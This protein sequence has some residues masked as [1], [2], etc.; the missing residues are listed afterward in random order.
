MDT[1]YR[2]CEAVTRL[3]AANFYYG[4]RLLPAPKQR[5]MCAIY[6]FARRVDDIG[7]GELPRDEKIRR[8]EAERERL[9]WNGVVDDPVIA[10]LR[11]VHERFSLPLDALESLIDGV[12][13]DARGISYGSFAELVVYCRQVAGS[14]GRLSLAIFGTSEWAEASALADDLGVAMQL[15]NILRDVREDFERGRLYL[16]REDFARFGCPPDPL[17]SPAESM[18]ELIRFEAERNR[19]WFSRGLALLPLLDARSAA[20]VG[21]MTGI[22]RRILECIERAPEEVVRRRISLPVWEK[23]WVAAVALANGAAGGRRTFAVRGASNGA[24]PL[25]VGGRGEPRLTHPHDGVA[26]TENGLAR[27]EDRVA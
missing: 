20:C 21:A 15:T 25:P 24:R 17:A 26:H 4:I 13:A 12:E 14:I 9:D 22:Y 23:A 5:A 18:G 19:E 11:D 3:E 8:L 10:A 7:D 16:P 27:S 2:L 1:A 6:A